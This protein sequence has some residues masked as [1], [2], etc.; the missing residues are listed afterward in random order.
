MNLLTWAI[1]W[2]VSIEAVEDLRR[3]FGLTG[4]DPAPTDAHT[5]SEAAIQTRIRLEAS[6]L[7]FRVWRNNVGAFDARFPPSPGS[8]WGLANDT[9]QMNTLVKS[10]DLIGLRPVLITPGHV[11]ATIGQFVAREVKAADWTYSGTEHENAQL[12]FLNIVAGLGGDAAFA[13][14]VGTL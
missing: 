12:N 13:N 11:G 1:R 9:K 2:G 5:E 8:R 3:E 10:S 14:G 6:G 7:G 4:T